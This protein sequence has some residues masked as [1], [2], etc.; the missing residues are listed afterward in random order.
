MSQ[1]PDD[2][3]KALWQGQ[4]TETETMTA[5][6]IRALARNYADNARGKMW[7]GVSLAAFEFVVFGRLAWL[8]R[9]EVLRAGYLL[10]LAGLL[11][12]TWRIVSRRPLPVPA[13]EA[14]ALTLIEF[15][16]AQLER[17]RTGFGWM[18]V[19]AAPMFVGIVIAMVGLHQDRPTMNWRNFAPTVI[20]SVA[21]FVAAYFLQR[22]QGRRLAA[23]I[24]E[25]DDLAGR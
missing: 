19:T 24:A 8:A 4:D 9:N 17:Q 2:R 25:M 21:W 20:L 23:Q 1:P 16:R 6:A 22:R 5:M 10:L 7:L 11:W 14:S 15:H 13:T 12:F 3:L 18:V